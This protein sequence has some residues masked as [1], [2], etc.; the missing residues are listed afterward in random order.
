ML[1]GL[2]RPTSGTA[3]VGGID[4]ARDPEAVKRRIGYMSQKFSL[5]ELLTVEENITFFGGLYGLDDRRSRARR[6]FALEM[7]GL[8]GR[9]RT[10]TRDLAGG[11]RQRLALGCAI[12]HEPPI[13]FLD[14]PTGGVDPVSRRQFW[15]LIDR[16]SADGRHRLRHHALPGR[17]RALPP[18]GADARRAH[19]GDGHGQRA[20]ERHSPTARSWR[21]GPHRR[22][23]RCARSTACRRSRRP[24]CSAR[25]CTCGCGRACSDT[26]PLRGPAGRA[27]P[28]RRVARARAA[29]ARGR[30]H[31]R[32]RTGGRD[33]GMRKALA[34]GRRSSGRSCATAHADDPA[35]R[36]GV[37]PDALR[38]R[39]ELRHPAR[40]ARGD[41]PRAQRRQPRRSSRRSST[42]RYFDMVA[43][44]DVDGRDRADDGPR[45]RSARRSSSPRA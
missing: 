45:D 20:Q 14:E 16:F 9:E 41:G 29:V 44:V 19:R 43:D 34:V 10:L 31:G 38:L 37:L 7:A 30:L 11:W 28:R 25:P 33:G 27:R 36:A 6:A 8:E 40:P 4:V 3:L 24:A 21:C 22:W 18:P 13:L 23:R 1:C 2:L 35:V 5:Y 15:Q 39:A 32:G 12:L 42:R 17:G 26:A